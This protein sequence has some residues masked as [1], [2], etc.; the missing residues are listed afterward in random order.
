MEY[1]HIPVSKENLTPELVDHFR[2]ELTRIPEPVFVHCHEKNRAGAL[3]MM[4]Q[5]IES[6][7][8]GDETLE[9]ARAIGFECDHPHLEQFVSNYVDSRSRTYDSREESFSNPEAFPR[10]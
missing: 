3:T 6:G 8:S 7:L 9:H 2:T 5:A 1:R 4:H 10:S